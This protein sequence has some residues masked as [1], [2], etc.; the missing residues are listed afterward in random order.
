[1]LFRSPLECYDYNDHGQLPPI[2]SLDCALSN[3]TPSRGAEETHG[4]CFSIA[5]SA[6]I[7]DPVWRARMATLQ[8][9]IR[10]SSHAHLGTVLAMLCAS[11]VAGKRT[12]SLSTPTSMPGPRCPLAVQTT[13]TSLLVSNAADD[14]SAPL[15]APE[16]GKASS[17]PF[18]IVEDDCEPFSFPILE[19]DSGSDFQLGGSSD[20][21][22]CEY[23]SDSD[24]DL[25]SDDLRLSPRHTSE[26]GRAHV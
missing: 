23:D 3:N 19:E 12:L 24:S 7:I 21:S 14:V 17:L 22:G 4:V 5:S 26:I 10:W 8:R 13:S 11:R 25:D 15:N 1:M 2:P 16:P 18:P 20:Q 6:T 9:E